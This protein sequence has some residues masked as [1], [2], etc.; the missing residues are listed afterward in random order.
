MTT[1]NP[2]LAAVLVSI[3]KPLLLLVTFVPWAWLI[4]SK[5]DKDARY[6][7]LK[8]HMWNG[9]HLGAGVAALVAALCIPWFW[10]VGW[11]VA[12]LIL[13]APVLAYWKL[14]NRALPEAQRFH[15]TGAD[16]RKRLS[17][18]RQARAAGG[19]MI[20][21]YDASG[22]ECP[23]PLKDDPLYAMHILAEDVIGPA[24]ESRASQ[25][26]VS[27]GS[28]GAAVSQLVDGI[29]YK[30]DA[31]PAESAMSMLDYLKGLA[32][33]NVPDRRK[34]QSAVFGL[35]A[36]RGKIK[37]TL[38]TAGSSSA[39]ELRLVIDQAK[40]IS[41]PFDGLG[42][43]ASQLQALRALEHAENRHGIVLIGAPP[44]QGLTTSAYSFV[45][46]HDAYTS[47]IK[48][49]EREVLMRLDGVDHVQFNPSDPETDYAT[50]LQSILRRDPDV[51]LVGD[52]PD[53]A[54]AQVVTEPGPKGPLLYIPR[55]GATI[56]GI[57]RDWVK[58]VG[59][60]KRAS[61]A[62]QAVTNQ[63]LLRT[64]CPNC[65]QPYAPSAEQLAKMGIPAGKV[66]HLYQANGKVQVKNKIEPCPVCAGT[67]YFGQTGAFEVLIAD[68]EIRRQLLLGDLKAVLAHARRNKMIYLQ[69]AALSKVVAGETTIEEVI[70]VTAPPRTAGPEAPARARPDPA[71]A[72]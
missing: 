44:G 17:A 25:V 15:L 68:D 1:L 28:G 57:L 36:P 22:K 9:L 31:L 37:L 20:R 33:L 19:A 63:R 42:L 55:H 71:P 72:S 50:R 52:V 27:V 43:L 41:K 23:V 62:I 32:G 61:G 47:N 8:R 69:E 2:F 48:T 24:L 67:G 26:D 51:V 7:H 49:L 4:S 16:F 45:G 11:P 46:R 64:L 54:T 34:R 40:Q 3:A 30:R 14:R 56:T 39:V 35:L 21:F 70:R 58:L 12:V 29:R 38:T 13:L 65:R 18:R 53:R 66:K 59:D 5:L 60:L 10:F 6:F